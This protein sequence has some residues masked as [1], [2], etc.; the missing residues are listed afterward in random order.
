MD[1]EI[2][3]TH[4]DHML[5][6]YNSHFPLAQIL[7]ERTVEYFHQLLGSLAVLAAARGQMAV[8]HHKTLSFDLKTDADGTFV[9]TD[10]GSSGFYST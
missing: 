3:V 7:L 10:A 2:Q 4:E 6:I 9:A 1:S 5:V 8:D